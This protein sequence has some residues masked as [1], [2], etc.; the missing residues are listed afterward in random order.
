MRIWGLMLGC[1]MVLCV[2]AGC[3]GAEQSGG[4]LRTGQEAQ[5]GP[6]GDA[7]EVVAC[8]QR[9]LDKYVNGTGLIDYQ[10]FAA[11]KDV[12]A[13]LEK[14]LAFASRADEKTHPEIFRDSKA[15]T[16]FYVNTYNACCLQGVLKCYPFESLKKYP[17][18]FYEGTT[19][20]VS[21][22][23]LSL[24]GL[25]Q[26]CGVEQDWRVAFALSEPVRE[27]VRLGRRAYEAGRLDEQLAEAVKDYLGS[28]S[29]IQF[30]PAQKKVLFGKVIYNQRKDWL[31]HYQDKYGT[32]VSLISAVIPWA[33]LCTQKLLVDWVGSGVTG[34]PGSD[35]LN[36]VERQEKKPP[37]APE[38]PV[39][40]CWCR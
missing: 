8:Y 38:K 2:L 35:A 30:D 11:D 12:R 16:A 7:N 27:G 20:L 22:E 9:V 3:E 5:G 37:A 21:Q 34:L 33:D 26:R 36:D 31:R 25:R 24:N 6:V 10:K 32:K 14:Y 23:P 28:C 17:G 39:T 19:F 29:G 40:I 1:V 13:D 18:K 4:G 15:R